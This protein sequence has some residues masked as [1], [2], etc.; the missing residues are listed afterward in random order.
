M[1]IF[2]D[3]LDLKPYM[4]QTHLNKGRKMNKLA[5]NRRSKF[6]SNINNRL[7]VVT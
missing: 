4:K 1:L 3:F 5:C 7:E 6:L 2:N